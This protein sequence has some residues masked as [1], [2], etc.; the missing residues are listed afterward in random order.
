MKNRAEFAFSLTDI[1]LAMSLTILSPDGLAQT[2]M[3]ALTISLRR[4]IVP[5]NLRSVTQITPSGDRLASR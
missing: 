3:G 2:Q 4:F 1:L 5:N